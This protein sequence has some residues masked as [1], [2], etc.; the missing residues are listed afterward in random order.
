MNFVPKTRIKVEFVVPDYVD[1]RLG[2][3]E[4]FLREYTNAVVVEDLIESCYLSKDPSERTE[5]NPRSTLSACQY[6]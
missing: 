5:K 2:D 1:V 6:N 4:V 3:L